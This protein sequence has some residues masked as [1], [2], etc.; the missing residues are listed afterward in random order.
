MLHPECAVLKSPLPNKWVH[1]FG[2]QP[3][4][5]FQDKGKHTRIF[6]QGPARMASHPSLGR[7]LAPIC[8]LA[9][10]GLFSASLSS[11]HPSTFPP[12]STTRLCFWP[13]RVS[14]LCTW[15]LL[16]T[17]PG[18]KVSSSQQCP[19]SSWESSIFSNYSN[20]NTQRKHCRRRK[21]SFHWWFQKAQ[22]PM[23]GKAQ[24]Q[25]NSSGTMNYMKWLLT[26]WWIQRIA[27]NQRWGITLKAHL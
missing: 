12:Q 26:W 14:L 5:A 20:N 23:M 1:Y 16:D 9:S 15:K 2:I 7:A 8:N 21:G 24:A 19:T 22:C 17:L 10:S 25:L 13:S 4:S 27:W 18:P 11:L 3:H 6:Y